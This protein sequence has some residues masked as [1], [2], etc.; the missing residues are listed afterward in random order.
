MDI[1]VKHSHETKR[2][3]APGRVSR[4]MEYD[5]RHDSAEGGPMPVALF[6]HSGILR[7]I[8]AHARAAYPEECCGFLLG[9]REEDHTR[10]METLR[11]VNE[12]RVTPRWEYAMS[13][14]AYLEAERAAETRGLEVTGFYH[15]HPDTPP[16]PSPADLRYAWPR[17]VYLVTAIHGGRPGA[18]GAFVLAPQAN[19]FQTIAI[20]ECN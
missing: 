16:E 10:V 17:M 13:P 15:S 9:R 20:R 3:A 19:S 11:S 18:M 5:Q 6:V 1:T 4:A 14:R 8:R 7:D 12:N 2:I